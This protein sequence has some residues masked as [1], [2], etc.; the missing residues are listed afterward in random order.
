MGS[1][2]CS[3]NGLVFFIQVVQL[4]EFGAEVTRVA[5]EVGTEGKLGGVAI[6]R[7]VE[8]VWN[9]LT[10]N[11]CCF[12]L[13]PYVNDGFAFFFSLIGQQDVSEP[14]F[15]SALHRQGYNSS[16]QC[17]VIPVFGKSMG[18]SELI[19]LR[20]TLLDVSRYPSKERWLGSRQQ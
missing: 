18:L 7:D 4:R 8:G 12:Y 17:R 15:A 11:V 10:T 3:V 2:F 5:L 16:R 6:V 20:A 1:V 13:G 9:E 19:S 14:Y